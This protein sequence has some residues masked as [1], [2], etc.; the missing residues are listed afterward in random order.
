[1]H[2]RHKSRA[3]KLT[4][5]ALAAHLACLRAHHEHGDGSDCALL[6]NVQ[7]SV[8]RFARKGVRL[9]LPPLLRAAP[10]ES[11]APHAYRAPP[12][13][14]QAPRTRGIHR[15]TGIARA[16]PRC[17]AR[18]RRS[19]HIAE[20][21]GPHRLGKC[22]TDRDPART[23]PAAYP[24]RHPDRADRTSAATPRCCAARC[25]VPRGHSVFPSARVR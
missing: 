3:V 19:C 6:L 5:N 21:F 13:R 14:P 8:K 4:H 10:R 2:A 9:A 23:Y 12:L 17:R 1:M 7:S 22:H 15:R 18:T 16:A 24:A 11:T 20:H 25:R